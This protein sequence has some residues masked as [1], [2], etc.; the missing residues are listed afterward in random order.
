VV[1]G[2]SVDKLTSDNFFRVFFFDFG[3]FFF[4]NRFD[5]TE[6]ELRGRN[7]NSI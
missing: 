5:T 1:D 3:G 7:R 2:E 6:F 4:I